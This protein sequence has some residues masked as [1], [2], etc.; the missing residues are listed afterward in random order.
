MFV[1][2]FGVFLTGRV[3]VCC[4]RVDT[5]T[6]QYARFATPKWYSLCPTKDVTLSFLVCPRKDV[7]FPFLE[8]V[9]S[10]INKKIIFPLSI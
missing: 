8:K 7:T 9:L 6:T 1:F 5:I 10:H 3:R 2:V 4:Y